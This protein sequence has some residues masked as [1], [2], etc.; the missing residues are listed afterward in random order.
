MPR[1]AGRLA[2]ALGAAAPAQ[3]PGGVT[4]VPPGSRID[5]AHVVFFAEAPPAS[6]APA[7]VEPAEAPP[8][9]AWLREVVR[10]TLQVPDGE[11]LDDRAIDDRAL[12]ALGMESLHAVA[13]QYQILEETGLDVSI[14]DL[15]AAPD[16][17]AL[18]ALLGERASEGVSAPVVQGVPG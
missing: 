8:L 6:V 2:S 14:D 11:A 15:F 3:W 17:T 1:F 7:E 13:L 5:L 16:V 10:T 18:A 4:L 9:L 12:V